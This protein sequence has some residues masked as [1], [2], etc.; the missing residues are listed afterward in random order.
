MTNSQIQ[1]N[2]IYMLNVPYIGLTCDTKSNW[3]A[4][5]V[6]DAY[7]PSGWLVASG[8]PVCF[9]SSGMVAT[10]LVK[11]CAAMRNQRYGLWGIASRFKNVNWEDMR[12]KRQPGNAGCG[13]LDCCQW[14]GAARVVIAA[15]TC[16]SLFMLN[17]K[18]RKGGGAMQ[19][20]A[21][22]CNLMCFLMELMMSCITT[23]FS[24]LLDWEH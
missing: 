16:R 13:Q 15:P 17:T 24:G 7:L 5:L 22:A 18:E 14:G 21:E 23:R 1:V 20:A 3:C 9:S 2:L 8:S 10:K 4:R 19:W 11:R 12:S 6:P